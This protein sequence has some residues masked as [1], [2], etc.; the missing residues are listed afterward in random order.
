MGSSSFS[1]SVASVI[2]NPVICLTKAVRLRWRGAVG[3]ISM[4]IKSSM[5]LAVMR[6]LPNDA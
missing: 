4:E 5:R 6:C 1:R 2:V 3:D